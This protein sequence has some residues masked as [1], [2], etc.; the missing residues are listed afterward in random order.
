MKNDQMKPD[1]LVFKDSP[2][3]LEINSWDDLQNIIPKGSAVKAIM[4]P[5]LYFVNGKMGIN[6][7]VLQIK[8]PNFEKIGKPITYAFSEQPSESTTSTTNVKEPQSEPTKTTD[9][10]EEEE[11]EEEEDEDSEV[12]V[13][14]N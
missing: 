14:D 7:R 12:E 5:K 1:V 8:L 4:Q 3:P 10:E 2:T 13:E 11:E 6:F 9:S